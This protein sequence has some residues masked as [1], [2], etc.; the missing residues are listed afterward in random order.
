MNSFGVTE[1]VQN[2]LSFLLRQPDKGKVV[3]KQYMFYSKLIQHLR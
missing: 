1:G 2:R 3:L